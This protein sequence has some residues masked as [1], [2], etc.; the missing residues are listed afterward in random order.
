MRLDKLTAKFQL[1]L[2]EAQSLAVGRG[3]QFIEP[4]HLMLAMLDQDGGSV[5]HLLAKGDVNVNRLRSALGEALD[6]LAKVEGNDGEVHLSNDLGKLLNVADK[7]AQERKDQYIASRVVR[8]R[9][10][11]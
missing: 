11:R 1:A 3:H 2:A 10:A 9:R 6:R 8:A 7:L 5:R 4:S